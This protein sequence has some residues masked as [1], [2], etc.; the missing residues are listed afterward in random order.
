MAKILLTGS[1]GYLGRLLTARLLS[2]GHQLV[3]LTPNA[4]DTLQPTPNLRVY[5]LDKT[6]PAEVFQTEDITGII[7]LAT[8]YGR[9]GESAAQM[10]GVNV[11]FPLN[12]LE[13]AIKHKADFFINTDT[14]LPPNLNPYAIT[15][16][17][18]ALWLNYF[19]SKIKAVNL[20]LDHFY[21][22]FD[23]TS[24]FVAFILKAMR[25]NAPAIN[26]TEGLQK[27]DFIYVDDVLDAYLAIINGLVKMQKGSLHTFEVATD[28]KTSIKELVLLVKELTGNTKTKL[29]FGA[30]PYRDNE[31]LE[32]QINTA[33]LRSL[34]WRAKTN[35]KDGLTKIIKEEGGILK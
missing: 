13:L 28:I 26:L 16:H 22:P 12:L 1:S 11:L 24:K 34:G 5:Q 8:L 15:K 33:A 35:L 9:A 32:Y 20:R 19:S 10:A 27:R 29:N 2:Q 31:M 14:I 7:H 30:L 4:S 21:G 3:A 6:S 23:N 25:D 18:F 17:Q